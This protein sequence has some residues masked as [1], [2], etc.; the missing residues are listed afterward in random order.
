MAERIYYLITDLDPGGAEKTLVALVTRL[1][2]ARYEPAVG[3]LKSEGPLAATLRDAGIP[4]ESFGMTPLS[5]P[6]AAIRLAGTLRRFRPVILHT[7]LFHANLA[8]R[9]AAKMAGVPAVI[10]SIRVAEGERRWHLV[11]DRMTQGLV[12]HNLAVSEGVRDFSIRQGGISPDK[13]TVIPNGVD[14]NA[15]AAAVPLSRES[16]G[17]P[18][19]APVILTVARLDR[20]KAVETLLAAV[21][22]VLDRHP[23]AIFIIAGEGPRR[24]PLENEARRRGITPAV[25]FLGKRDDVPQLLKT[26]DMF[27]LPS[28]WEGMP[29]ALLEAMAAGIPVAAT[30]VPGIR[31]IIRDGE[32]GHLFPPDDPAALARIIIRMLS[33]PEATRR[34]GTNAAAHV[35]QFHRFETMVEHTMK[36]YEEVLRVG[37]S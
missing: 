20:Q 30:R 37:E 11:S 24:G 35:R 15:C 5:L 14:A 33:D 27:A 3:C 18:E 22:E 13:I 29:N 21:P 25:R 12:S 36:I 17:I 19:G 31:E 16:L 23:S 28:R 1:D 6:F 2:R 9:F 10:S 34:L 26:A 32:T 8:G 4:V 7:W